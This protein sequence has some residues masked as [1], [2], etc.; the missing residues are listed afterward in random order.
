MLITKTVKYALAFSVIWTRDSEGGM[1]TG[2]FGDETGNL[3][4]ALHMLE[5]AK[6]NDYPCDNRDWHIRID[7][8]TKVTQ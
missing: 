4:E 6:A 3:E 5:L 1:D 2:S 7:V 8:E